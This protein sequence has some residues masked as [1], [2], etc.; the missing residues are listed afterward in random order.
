[1]C[2]WGSRTATPSI[3]DHHLSHLPLRLAS[4][5]LIVSCSF[6]LCWHRPIPCTCC[7]SREPTAAALEILLLTNSP[8]TS[9]EISCTPQALSPCSPRTR[10]T[11][12]PSQAKPSQA[13]PSQ[14]KPNQVKSSQ[15]KPSQDEKTKPNQAKPNRAKS[16]QA[17]PSQ[18]EPNQALSAWYEVDAP[19]SSVS[20][21]SACLSAGSAGAPPWY[22]SR[23]QLM[24]KSVCL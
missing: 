3:S 13:K 22:F 10:S 6:C 17:R 2:V 21:A 12:K 4:V 9:L 5:A 8:A 1:M 15:I 11:L 19:A 7:L 14:A 24:N 20:S 23:S 18:I 16:S